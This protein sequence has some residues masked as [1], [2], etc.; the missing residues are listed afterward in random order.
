MIINRILRALGRP[1]RAL[2]EPLVEILRQAA[3]ARH[4]LYC[5]VT[6]ADQER[7]KGY[8]RAFYDE[9]DEV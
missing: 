1:I 9:D 7:H 6:K 3:Y 4:D 8:V 5:I 2:P